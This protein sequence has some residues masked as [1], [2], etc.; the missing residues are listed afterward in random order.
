MNK[1]LKFKCTPPYKVAIL[2]INYFR[3]HNFVVSNT[4]Q[5]I[6]YTYKS[7]RDEKFGYRYLV[8]ESQNQFG[9]YSQL[10]HT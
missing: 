5:R 2:T 1:Q 9:N 6:P 8:C 7:D 4:D 10:K 3:K